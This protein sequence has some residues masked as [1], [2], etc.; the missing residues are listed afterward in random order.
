MRR[1][2][3]ARLALVLAGAA[4]LGS[5][6]AADLRLVG[7][8][9]GKALVSVD[10]AAPRTL[11]VGQKTPEGVTLVG[12]D[13]QQ[14]VF[15]VNGARRTLTIGQGFSAGQPTH[16]GNARTVLTADEQGHFWAEGSVNGGATMRF[17]VD[18]GATLIALPAADARR[19]GLDYFNAPR[20]AVQTANGTA[21]AHFVKLDR[22]KI[23]DI[24]LTNVDAV[25]QE[26]GLSTP[27][28]G[29]SF[30]NRTDMQRAGVMMT[31]V[32]RF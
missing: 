4:L 2:L 5:A 8:F 14:A 32:R 25:V 20:G 30:L 16:G 19:I 6:A 21:I 27:L 12:V 24:T 23:G 7:V 9:T 15:E 18:T 26:G 17:L 11:A 29:M 31:L 3:P 1:A 28:L 10:G 13:G 22:V